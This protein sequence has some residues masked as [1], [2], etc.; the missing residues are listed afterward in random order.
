[1]KE[2]RKAYVLEKLEVVKW[3]VKRESHYSLLNILQWDCHPFHPRDKGNQYH[4]E[5][6]IAKRNSQHL[7]AVLLSPSLTMSEQRTVWSLFLETSFSL[8]TFSWF[9][10]SFTDF[11]FW[12]FQLLNSRGTQM[13]VPGLYFFSMFPPK[14]TSSNVNTVYKQMTIKSPSSIWHPC[15]TSLQLS[16]PCIPIGSVEEKKK[17]IGSI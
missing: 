4:Q 12:S 1:M 17:K 7:T 16:V 2:P 8:S 13:L 10:S 14:A 3:I 6:H 11:H 9:S 5:L 15:C